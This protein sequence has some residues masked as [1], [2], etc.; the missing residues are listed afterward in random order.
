[1]CGI[2]VNWDAVGAIGTCLGSIATFITVIIALYPYIKRGKLYFVKYSNI[3]QEPVLTIINGRAEGMHIE[4]IVFYAG[5]I[6]FNKYFFEDGFM[7]F[8]D[9]L[10]SDKTTNCLEPYAS[11]KISYNSTRIIHF[12]QHSGIQVGRLANYNMR[13]AVFTHNKKMVLNTKIKTK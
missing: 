12:M 13:I 2:D 3:E 1:M 8:E 11:K 4:K 9:D 10:V 6:L 7:E 5:P